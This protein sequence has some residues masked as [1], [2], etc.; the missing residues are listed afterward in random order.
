MES[1]KLRLILI[2]LSWYSYL[3][4]IYQ[5]HT[6]YF[7]EFNTKKAKSHNR[8][9]VYKAFIQ[10]EWNNKSLLSGKI[11]LP[12]PERSCVKI[13]NKKCINYIVGCR[14]SSLWR[15]IKEGRV[16]VGSISL[17]SRHSAAVAITTAFF[18]RKWPVSKYLPHDIVYFC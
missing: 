7:Q 11:C 5:S 16:Y 4:K 15:E 13:W 3:G 12:W 6:I 10:W 1:L 14:E 8:I 9:T 18:F 2:L 17:Y